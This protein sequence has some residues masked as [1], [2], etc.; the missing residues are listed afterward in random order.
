MAGKMK[1]LE[2]SM[3]GK[4]TVTLSRGGGDKGGEEERLV[5]PE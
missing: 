3:S 2:E 1:A 4:V 5:E